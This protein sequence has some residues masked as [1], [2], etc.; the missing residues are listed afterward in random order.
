MDEQ[1]NRSLKSVKDF[2][3]LAQLETNVRGRG[4]FYGEVAVAFTERAEII[5]REVIEQRTGLDLSQLT[6]AEE[7]I[8]RAVSEYLAIK[9]R[10][11][12]DSTRTHRSQIDYYRQIVRQMVGRVLTKNRGLTDYQMASIGFATSMN[13]R[14][15]RRL[16]WATSARHGL[17][18]TSNDER[19]PGHI[20]EF[21]LAISQAR[22]D[23]RF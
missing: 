16:L 20:V 2:K 21:R 4:A 12:S 13:F 22:C 23:T 7:K 18:N 17:P 19:I 1:I 6:P 11:G 9:Q 15:M 10:D 3:G 8:V 5:A 14:V